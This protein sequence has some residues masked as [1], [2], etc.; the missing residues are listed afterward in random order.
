[1]LVRLVLVMFP[2]LGWSRLCLACWFSS[3]RVNSNLSGFSSVAH[4]R[5]ISTRLPSGEW[6][7]ELV[8][9]C[10]LMP[11]CSHRCCSTELNCHHPPPHSQLA[12][13][14][15]HWF[16]AMAFKTTRYDIDNMRLFQNPAINTDDKTWPCFFLTNDSLRWSLIA[17]SRTVGGAIGD[18]TGTLWLMTSGIDWHHCVGIR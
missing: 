7:L 12:P 3:T 4:S 9:A 5:S 1:M 8:N 17:V 16:I 6:D 2:R 14:Q 18:S 11:S 10:W 13:N 15:H